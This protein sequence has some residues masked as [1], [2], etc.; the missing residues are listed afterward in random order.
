MRYQ[1]KSTNSIPS[2]SINKRQV[3]I[4]EVED[5]IENKIDTTSPSDYHFPSSLATK[6]GDTFG[7]IGVRME[8]FKN[9]MGYVLTSFI[10]MCDKA[11]KT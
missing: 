4:F 5:F 6:T 1:I 10:Q 2:E 9:K 11:L 8:W 3:L 7:K